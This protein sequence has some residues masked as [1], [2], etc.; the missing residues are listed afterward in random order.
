MSNSSH[1]YSSMER[2]GYDRSLLRAADNLSP[3]DKAIKYSNSKVVL[4]RLVVIRE[5]IDICHE[6]GFVSTVNSLLPVI[7]HLSNDNDEE[8]R[9][10]ALSILGDFVGFLVQSEPE[11]G[12]RT[13]ISGVIPIVKSV[14]LEGI[15]DDEFVDKIKGTDDRRKGKSD[16]KKGFKS[17]AVNSEKQIGFKNSRN[18]ESPLSS[19]ISVKEVACQASITLCSHLRHFDR[20]QYILSIGLTLANDLENEDSR[21]L[22]TWMLNGIAE[23]VGRDLCR[24]YIIPQ[25]RC[26][27]DDH[28]ERVRK[29]AAMNLCEII[30]I[31]K[32]IGDIF[33][34]YKRLVLHDT[35]MVRLCAVKVLLGISSSINIT[36]EKNFFGLLLDLNRE[37]ILFDDIRNEYLKQLGPLI[38]LFPEPEKVPDEIL[39]L[40]L[41][42][43]NI[44]NETVKSENS[45]ELVRNTNGY[46]GPELK[47][48]DANLNNRATDANINE[49]KDGVSNS[50]DGILK[51]EIKLLPFGNQ[52]GLTFRQGDIEDPAYFCSFSFA[53][54]FSHV[55]SL[56]WDRFCEL[57]S[58][59]A[60]NPRYT[61]RLPVAAS[62]SLILENALCFCEREHMSGSC[63]FPN[64]NCGDGVRSYLDLSLSRKSNKESGPTNSNWDRDEQN[65]S[66]NKGVDFFYNTSIN[67][68][69]N[70]S[71]NK[72]VLSRNTYRVLCSCSC[73]HTS[74]KLRPLLLVLDK[75][76]LDKNV[77]VKR[78]V[79]CC[80]SDIVRCLPFEYQIE[81]VFKKLP[82]ILES[83]DN[84]WRSRNI[85]AVQIRSICIDLNLRNK[86]IRKQYCMEKNEHEYYNGN[87]V[88]TGKH[89][90]EY[91][92]P[93]AF[94][95]ILDPVS[96]VRLKALDCI[97]SLLRLSSP[98][99]WN[100]FQN[101]GNLHDLPFP[102]HP[103]F[104]DSERTKMLTSC[105][106]GESNSNNSLSS[107]SI[108]T[109]SSAS[110]GIG[111][112]LNLTA[113][114]N[115]DLISTANNCGDDTS[116]DLQSESKND[117]KMERDVIFM[118]NEMALIWCILKTFAISTKYHH[119]QEY[120]KMC[121][122]FIRDIPRGFFNTYFLNPLI[123]LTSD[124]VRNVR[125][126][127]LRIIGP[128]I[129]E[130]GRLAQCGNIVAACKQMKL[131]EVDSECIKSFESIKFLDK[132]RLK[133]VDLFSVKDISTIIERTTKYD[134]TLNWNQQ[135]L[136]KYFNLYLEEVIGSLWCLNNIPGSVIGSSDDSSQTNS[137]RGRLSSLPSSLVYNYKKPYY[138]NERCSDLTMEYEMMLME[139]RP[140]SLP[141]KFN[142]MHLD[143][144]ITS[145]INNIFTINGVNIKDIF[146][147]NTLF[148][149]PQLHR[150]VLHNIN[151]FKNNETGDVYSEE[152]LD[153]VLYIP[154][155]Y[156]NYDKFTCPIGTD[157]IYNEINYN[158]SNG[159]VPHERPGKKNSCIGKK[160]ATDGKNK[161]TYSASGQ[162][163]I[164]K[165]NQGN[166]KNSINTANKDV[167]N[168]SFDH[169]LHEVTR[170]FFMVDITR[171]ATDDLF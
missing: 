149:R 63:Y 81:T 150:R 53:A 109:S 35:Y 10:G 99:I 19:S 83:C 24:Q 58:R 135:P 141:I 33:P 87:G 148:F 80:L 38:T 146:P 115:S 60:G 153:T 131:S 121:D 65:T 21:C 78:A 72:N 158:S 127:W 56:N 86:I 147:D 43:D 165:K 84:D 27:G 130:S 55:G 68:D 126:T 110:D 52:L 111:K 133:R 129:K 98:Y 32:E 90:Q 160:S 20:V 169:K 30:R 54:V 170:R 164:L 66:V 61:V 154:G 42:M 85:L 17:A 151:E 100:H 103:P 57:L 125:S 114:Q 123:L 4:Q 91:I 122:R 113:C 82:L 22:S 138:S 96:A 156:R 106:K 108:S 144:V 89:A 44:D 77:F 120:I 79:L 93:I 163:A 105:N 75:L 2:L 45:D 74:E 73:T 48:I 37:C 1:P 152:S 41:S 39:D 102:I 71:F 13:V 97:S 25:I 143:P 76:L 159:S 167:L 11:K 23:Y 119:R 94:S 16:F 7:K 69:M 161:N 50:I 155:I 15:Y 8:V 26:L 46:I 31:N 107:S 6:I 67:G 134:D 116:H 36:S 104:K 14:L 49:A 18:C 112:M 118:L 142:L 59:L 70:K 101:G 34:T 9:R 162:K 124:P 168:V 92:S 139:V 62:I 128:H 136:I 29:F 28:S 3:L 140:N 137:S 145:D 117:K 166:N 5:F 88:F 95:L 40:Y 51:D 12:Y 171:A 132:G 47:D 64:L 157:N